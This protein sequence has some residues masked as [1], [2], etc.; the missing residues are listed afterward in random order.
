MEKDPAM[1]YKYREVEA[2]R[3]LYSYRDIDWKDVCGLSYNERIK[4]I[5]LFPEPTRVLVLIEEA[6]PFI[7]RIGKKK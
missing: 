7:S 2:Y 3:P 6:V 4:S 1:R 5:T